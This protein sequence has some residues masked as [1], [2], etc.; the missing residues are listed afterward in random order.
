MEDEYGKNGW[1]ER[2]IKKLLQKGILAKTDRKC[3]GSINKAT[4][5][6]G[7]RS[8]STPDRT[9]DVEILDCRALKGGLNA[10]IL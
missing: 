10:I 3:L 6:G 1:W 9:K 7:W 8:E 4:C 2:S 5:L